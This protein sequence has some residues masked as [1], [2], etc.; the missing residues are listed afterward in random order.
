V[1]ADSEA[2]RARVD[3]VADKRA[4]MALIE[5]SV[6]VEGEGYGGDDGSGG[7]ALANE[8]GQFP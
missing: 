2:A 5:R 3:V 7:D 6:L 4:L 1:D 8:V